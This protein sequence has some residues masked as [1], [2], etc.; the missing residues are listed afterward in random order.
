MYYT[1]EQIMRILNEIAPFETQEPWDNSGLMIG[2]PAA[3]VTGVLIDMD[4]TLRSIEQA[5]TNGCNLIVT[6]HPFFFPSVRSVDMATPSGQIL[7]NLIKNDIAVISAH[8][9]L[10]KATPGVN[11]ALA[12]RLGL[13][14]IRPI[15]GEEIGLVGVCESQTCGELAANAKEILGS[16][17]LRTVGDTGK[18]V[19]TV[20]VCGGAGG[21][22]TEVCS[23]QGIDALVSA[24]FKHHQ[25]VFAQASGLFLI[26]A[27]HYETEYPGLW[28]LAE[29]L[30]VRL[31]C[32]I[33]V[34]EYAPPFQARSGR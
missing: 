20:A 6:H 11:H 29:Q 18:K 9:N 2:D 28:I 13:T 8:T 25:A 1:V 10:D 22:L 23:R 34:A 32:P 21:D 4:L 30:A 15:E 27:G 12:V 5:M 17:G 24:E 19:R 3:I 7:R 16:S 31:D 26:D 33:V 14:D